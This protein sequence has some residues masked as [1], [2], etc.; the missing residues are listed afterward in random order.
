LASPAKGSDTYPSY[1]F[2]NLDG[3]YIVKIVKVATPETLC[4]LETILTNHCELA[5]Q[6]DESEELANVTIELKKEE[7][8]E[9]EKKSKTKAEIA[10]GIISKGG[11]L[12][13]TG[14]IK[15]AELLSTGIGKIG[16]FVQK[17]YVKKSP[18]KEINEST[19]DKLQVANTATKAFFTF[20]QAKAQGIMAVA[21]TIGTEIA[22]KAMKTEQGKKFENSK[23]NGA[24]KEIG[25][26]TIHAA[27]CI[28]SGM[29]EA[30]SVLGK[31]LG[32]TTTKIVNF[33]YGDKAGT[34]VKQGF[35][36]AGN[37][38]NI[39]KV[40]QNEAV[41]VIAETTA[42]KPNGPS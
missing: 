42:K 28:Y 31:G 19:F 35:E 38:G 7:V 2:P 17:K 13:K 15:S 18:E 4:S 21:K 6:E 12:T 24:I 27:A 29:A 20:T 34:A 40:Y 41:K 10:S 39:T 11:E 22:V 1:V 5:Y 30:M 25:K 8:K 9:A 26:S 14:L 23:Y 32:D 3:Y 16:A 33:K 36:V 37:I